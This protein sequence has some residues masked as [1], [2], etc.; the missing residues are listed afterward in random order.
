M[1]AVIQ[2]VNEANVKVKDKIVG[3]INKGLVILLGVG[4]DDND[5]AAEYLANKIISLRIFEDSMGKM[6]NS[7][8]D[9]NGELLIV[10][11][12][13]IYG[14]CRKGRRPSFD[15]AAKQ[16]QAYNL[17]NY[18]VNYCKKSE[19]KVE[20]GIF[21]EKMTVSL[22]NDGPVTFILKSKE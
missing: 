1:K 17:Y 7:I 19:L 9:I 2:R 5:E 21:Q 15:Q 18:F 6:N 8:E 22:V 10:S 20:T 13:T 3:K 14:D 12:F 11:Q 16:E 4:K